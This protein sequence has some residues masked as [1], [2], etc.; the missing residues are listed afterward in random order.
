MVLVYLYDVDS[1]FDCSFNYSEL[2]KFWVKLAAAWVNFYQPDLPPRK[3]DTSQQLTEGR[4]P[5]H[6]FAR[7][8]TNVPNS[9]AKLYLT[10]R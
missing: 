1:R 10:L 7:D 9:T 6:I 4:D 8:S 5:T 2:G 3:L